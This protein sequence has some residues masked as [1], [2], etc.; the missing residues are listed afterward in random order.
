MF[1]ELEVSMLYLKN[2]LIAR[3]FTKITVLAV[4]M[5]VGLLIVLDILNNKQVLE[6]RTST[7]KMPVRWA[8]YFGFVLII[9]AGFMF[10]S[11]S[12]NFIF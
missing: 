6:V 7:F 12:Q 4:P 1:S 5:L 3:G 2:S 8:I 9:L 10:T 11:N